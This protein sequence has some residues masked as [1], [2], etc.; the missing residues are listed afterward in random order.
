M[1]PISQ[2]KPKKTIIK[3]RVLSETYSK[4]SSTF[5]GHDCGQA[6]QDIRTWNV[7]YNIRCG[8]MREHYNGSGTME[9]K[10]YFFSMNKEI[11]KALLE[12]FPRKSNKWE[13]S[14]SVIY[15]VVQG[16]ITLGL[17]KGF[18]HM[19]KGNLLKKLN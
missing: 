17:T 13:K 14:H 16:D 11:L 7:E 15:Q 5:N 8:I 6:F 9:L 2:G 1:T 3:E 12:N 10:T 19:K 4:S 18:Q